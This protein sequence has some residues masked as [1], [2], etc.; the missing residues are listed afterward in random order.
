MGFALSADNRD[1]ASM[2]LAHPTRFKRVAV[3]FREQSSKEVL[4]ASASKVA[5]SSGW[6]QAPTKFEFVINLKSA[7]SL[8]LSVPANLRALSDRVVER[9][10]SVPK[11]V[12]I[13]HFC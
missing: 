13:I 7:R 4:G 12:Q 11:L 10:P 1:R 8:G 5:R 9:V 2:L 6:S 3:A